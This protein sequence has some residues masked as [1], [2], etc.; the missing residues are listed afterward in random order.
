MMRVHILSEIIFE[1]LRF[2]YDVILNLN[3]QFVSTLLFVSIRKSTLLPYIPELRIWKVI[4]RS[5]QW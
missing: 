3:E 1:P 2:I 4:L 5:S